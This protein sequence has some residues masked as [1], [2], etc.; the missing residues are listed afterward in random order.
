MLLNRR[1]T[2]KIRSKNKK[3]MQNDS[4][5]RINDIL[6]STQGSQR[7]K[8]SENLLQQIE[9]RIDLVDRK[10]IPIQRLRLLAVAAVLL[11]LINIFAVSIYWQS[12]MNKDKQPTM[13]LISD[14]KLYE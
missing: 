5:K 1:K 13:T 8:P 14:Y 12:E 4:D 3:R 9:D 6:N 10:I 7:A 2:R 11:L